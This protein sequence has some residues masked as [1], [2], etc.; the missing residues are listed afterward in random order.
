MRVGEAIRLDRDD[1]DWDDR[2]LRIRDSKFG[3]SRLVVLHPSTIDALQDYAARRDEL[4]PSPRTPS[5]LV[6]SAGTRLIYC[7]VSSLFRKLVAIAGIESRSV[8]C[9]PRIHDF[10]HLFAIN[11]LIEWHGA[12][13][14]VEA[15]LPTLST[16][17]GHTDPKHTYWYLSATPQLL[18]LAAKRLESD[19]EE[20]WQ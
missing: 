19:G 15:R 14:D 8:R 10:R 2:T 5:F 3:K 4:C 9:R 1:I 7:N 17:L 12:G 11:T 20:D 13:V 6:S 18:A 16:F